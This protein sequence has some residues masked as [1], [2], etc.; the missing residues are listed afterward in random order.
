MGSRD[1]IALRVDFPTWPDHRNCC[2]G[3]G[4]GGRVEITRLGNRFLGVRHFHSALPG[5]EVESLPGALA[6][7]VPQT[8]RRPV[9]RI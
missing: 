8:A 3:W 1:P 5:E 4:S 6:A 7:Q 9:G 2:D